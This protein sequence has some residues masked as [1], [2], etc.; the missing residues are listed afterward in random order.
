MR[1][2]HDS[3]IHLVK[4]LHARRTLIV[5]F[6]YRGCLSSTARAH[7]HIDVPH[8]QTGAARNAVELHPVVGLR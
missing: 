3:D 5:E 2:E 1:L 6:P 4:R 8:G 7:S